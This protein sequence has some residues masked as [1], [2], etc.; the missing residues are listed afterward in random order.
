[1]LVHAREIA[2]G[3]GVDS[4]KEKD[5]PR[6]IDNNLDPVDTQQAETTELH[7]VNIYHEAAG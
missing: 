5:K 6:I 3:H 1:M 4:K 7:I 2:F